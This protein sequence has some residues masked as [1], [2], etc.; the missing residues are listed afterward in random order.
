MLVRLAET[1]RQF[2]WLCKHAELVRSFVAWKELLITVGALTF[3]RDVANED[4]IN[5]VREFR[6]NCCV[7]LR[8]PLARITHEHELALRE[9]FNEGTNSSHLEDVQSRRVRLQ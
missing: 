7:R 9:P 8:V 6:K 1:K 5:A 4:G 3:A 2:A